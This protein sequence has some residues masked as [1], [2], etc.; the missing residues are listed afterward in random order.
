MK[1]SFAKIEK[2]IINDLEMT[3]SMTFKVK[4]SDGIPSNFDV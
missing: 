2:N 3:L 4:C 1:T